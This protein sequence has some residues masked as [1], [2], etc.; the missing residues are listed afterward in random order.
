MSDPNVTKNFIA[1]GN[2][3]YNPNANPVVNVI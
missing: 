3:T 1:G 2:S